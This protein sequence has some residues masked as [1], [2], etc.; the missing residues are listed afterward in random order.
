MKHFK[1]SPRQENKNFKRATFVKRLSFE[2]EKDLK[3]FLLA[4]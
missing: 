2:S 3:Y 1:R 4:I